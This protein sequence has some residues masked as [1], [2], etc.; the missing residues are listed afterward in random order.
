MERAF[1]EFVKGT[2]LEDV[3]E[4]IHFALTSEDVNNIAYRLM[5]KRAIDAVCIPAMDKVV[6]KLAKNARD[7]KKIAMLARTH[8]QPA[9]P[10]VV[11]KDCANYAVRINKEVRELEKMQLTGKT[12]G[13][14]GGFNAQRFA[15]SQVNWIDL[16]KRF[17]ESFGFT[18]NL[19]TT[20]INP[21]ED[22]IKIFQTL[23]RTNNIFL[24]F[25]QNIWR[26]ISDDWWVQMSKAGVVGSS[27]MP[28]KINPKDFEN[29]EGNAAI[30]NGIWDVMVR[31]LPI[32]R[33]QRHLSDSTIIRNVGFGLAI[34]LLIYQN[35]MIGLD[36]ISPNVK[37]IKK[38]LNANYA[39]LSEAAQTAAR[40]ERVE[41]PYS[42]L[43]DR[44]KGK[45]IKP[46]EWKLLV[47]ELN[48]SD[49]LK[50]RLSK[51]TPKKY[52]GYAEALTDLAEEDIVRSR[53]FLRKDSNP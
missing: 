49:E 21:Y 39:I 26:Y 35:T 10:S 17:V 43:A 34:G 22:M 15:A 36:L 14:V 1:R 20:Q 18:P 5:L 48:V 44:V 27:I 28:Q 41:D 23:Q 50:S 2:S 32:S 38:S 46:S 6:D 37:V 42:L 16:S 4:M 19:F 31:T 45:K 8:G 7:Y 51:L 12:N 47:Q 29:S 33:L 13:T 3:I 30:A 25:D 9:V 53:G 40:L 11:G 52:T 24:D